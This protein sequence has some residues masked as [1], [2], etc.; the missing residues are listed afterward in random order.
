MLHYQ[1]MSE[2][3]SITAPMIEEFGAGY[4]MTPREKEVFRLLI[5]FG[6]RNDDMGSVLHISTK[7]LKNH[8]ACM[9][10]K[11]KTR[12]SRELQALFL[13]FMLQRFR[14]NLQS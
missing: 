12:S 7:T 4:R 8:M 10:N 2:T 6:F 3:D 1:V 14:H 5:L 11:T 13:Q 9:M